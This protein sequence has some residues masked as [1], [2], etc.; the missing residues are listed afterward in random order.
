MADRIE[1]T[2]ASATFVL[3]AGLV[4]ALKQI[5]ASKKVSVSELVREYL[6][7]AVVDEVVAA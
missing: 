4:F 2:P 1:Q 3:T 6:S 5:A 7:A